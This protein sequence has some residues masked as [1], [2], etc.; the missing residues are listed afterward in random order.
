MKNIIV[1]LL[2]TTFILS[3]CTPEEDLIN[4]EINII[5]KPQEILRQNGSF[6]LNKHTTICYSENNALKETAN[7]LK[8]TLELY[9]KKAVLKRTGETK[10]ANSSIILKIDTAANMQA[11]AYKL[12]I[13]KKN[14]EIIAGDAA[15]IF[16]GFQSLKQLLPADYSAKNIVLPLLE[17]NDAPRFEWRGMHLD[18]CRHFMPAAFVKKYIDYIAAMKMNRFHWHLTEDQGWR[19]EIKAYPNL[20]KKG[21]WRSETRI[22]HAADTIQK[23]DGTKHGGFYTQEEIKEIV[24]YAQKR[25]VSVIPEIEMPGHAQAAIAAY[26]FLGCTE[27]RVD[28]W[29][30]WGVSPYIY[31][32]KDTTFAFLETVLS[33]VFDLF[34]GK[35]V[36]IGGDEAIKEQWIESKEIQN[37]IKQLGLKNE[38]ELQSYFI[39]RIE[40]FVNSKGKTIIGWDE[41]LEGGL[42]PNAVVM[43]WRGTE[44]GIAAAKAGHYVIMSPGSHC[45]FDHYQ[46]KDTQNE[47]LAI[48]GFT[49]TEKVYSFEPMPEELSADKQKYI[50]G[51]QA[52]VWTEYILSPEHVEYMIF[53]RM[54]ALAEVLWTKPKLKDYENFCLRLQAYKKILDREKINY[55]A[56]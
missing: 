15:G 29:T 35:Y 22:G 51:A 16:Y 27:D 1:I 39:K 18:V 8:E 53:P 37:K 32:L 10:D 41:I 38:H 48:G 6:T 44:G 36:H 4:R 9:G 50:L 31:N 23:Y 2:A 56:F 42:A 52:N 45:Y 40:K 46:S 3:S 21:A 49:N 17:I 13:G 33:E 47:P 26:P 5:P 55:R 25:H 14:I 54:L 7:F 34:P 24:A 43:S 20:S 11:E 12:R 30:N 28:V 19:I